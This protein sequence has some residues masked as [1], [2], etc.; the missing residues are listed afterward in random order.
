MLGG[1]RPVSASLRLD[2]PT[3]LECFLEDLG[4]HLDEKARSALT[5]VDAVSALAFL[6]RITDRGEQVRNP[7][8]FIATAVRNAGGRGPGAAELESALQRLR[9]DGTLDDSA[10]EALH[11]GST[12]DACGAIASFL[13]QEVSAVRNA[14]AYVTRNIANAR[15]QSG[16]PVLARSVLARGGGM[17]MGSISAITVGGSAGHGN[18]EMLLA[19]WSPSLDQKALAALMAL[20]APAATAVLQEM[21]SKA[22]SVRNPSAYVQRA[23]E[24]RKDG[25]GAAAAVGLGSGYTGGGFGSGGAFNSGGYGSGGFGGSGG[26]GSGGAGRLQSQ[27]DSDAVDALQKVAPEQA[28]SILA[29]LESRAGA[30]RNPSAY[31]VRSVKNLQDGTDGGLAGGMGNDGS[32]TAELL[33]LHTAHSRPTISGPSSRRG[34]SEREPD[35]A[36]YPGMVRST[37]QWDDEAHSRESEIDGPL[38][39]ALDEGARQALNEIGSEAANA[40]LQ[41]LESQ[42]G[43]VNNPSAYVLRAVGNARRGKGAGGAAAGGAAA[44]MGLQ[45]ELAKLST[46]LDAKA[47]AALEE[48]GPVAATAIIQKLNRQGVTVNNPNAYIMR[49]VGNEKRG[50]V[51]PGGPALKRPRL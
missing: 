44:K 40:I 7:S 24:N 13:S 39:D 46:P 3:V 10:V 20:G 47:T 29:N 49:A 35:A 4:T 28:A 36:R 37:A 33:P 23:C 45:E 22:A 32:P 16:A 8:A 48:V 15:K 42:S 12:E 30:V 31:V 6:Q 11:K 41:Q 50:L 1:A 2:M 9:G 18:G 19:K 25:I 34:Y 27:L 14:S 38:I 21:D 51:V 43:K 26:G 5:Q 17:G